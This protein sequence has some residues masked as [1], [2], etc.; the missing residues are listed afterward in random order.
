METIETLALRLGI[1]V[2]RPLTDREARFVID[3]LVYRERKQRRFSS[4]DAEVQ[5]R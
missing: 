2:P 5:D 3:D 1:E 4:F